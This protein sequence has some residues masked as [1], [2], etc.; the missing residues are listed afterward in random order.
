[1]SA[2]RVD[3]RQTTL[4]ESARVR[5]AGEHMF[6]TMDNPPPVR[7]LLRLTIDGEEQAFEVAQV[8]EVVGEGAT[9]R[10]CFGSF[11]ELSRLDEHHKVGSE[12]L[13]PGI[14]GGGIPAPVVIMNT[15]EMML[16]EV[17]S[18]EGEAAAAGESVNAAEGSP[19][20]ESSES[21]E[22]E[23]SE[24]SADSESSPDD[25]SESSSSAES[26]S[27]ADGESADEPPRE[28]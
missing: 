20:S 3:L 13:Q 22:S 17:G 1:M 24:G 11:I 8:V 4:T 25:A 12:H 23:S 6:L 9:E 10:G 7:S 18:D 21:S 26:S 15:N 2:V 28:D 16:G 14:S 5:E 19:D 27:D